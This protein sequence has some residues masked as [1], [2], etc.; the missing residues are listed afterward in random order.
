MAKKSIAKYLNPWMFKRQKKRERLT[1]LLARDGDLC[2]HCGN[3]MRLGPPHNIGKAVTI[4]HYLPKAMG[5]TS[6]LENLRLCHVRCNRHL[7]ASPP[8][9][10]DR[11]RLAR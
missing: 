5:G 9:Q 1:A 2:W 7:G 4:E 3:K 8:E 6:A 11:M 10:K